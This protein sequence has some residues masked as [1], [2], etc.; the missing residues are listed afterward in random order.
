MIKDVL[1]PLPV[2]MSLLEE[3]F[4]SSSGHMSLRETLYSLNVAFAKTVDLIF[5]FTFMHGLHL[6][7]LEFFC[8]F[9]FAAFFAAFCLTSLLPPYYFT[10]YP[11]S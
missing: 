10:V 11:S 2:T 5:Q 6:H 8:L 9:L 1:V 7:L 3:V 4:S